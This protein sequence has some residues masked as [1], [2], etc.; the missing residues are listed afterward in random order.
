MEIQQAQVSHRRTYQLVSSPITTPMERFRARMSGTRR[1]VSPT[2]SACSTACDVDVSQPPHDSKGESKYSSAGSGKQEKEAATDLA[3]ETGVE[4]TTIGAAAAVDGKEQANGE[5]EGYS[6]ARRRFLLLVFCLASV[7]CLLHKG[8]ILTIAVSGYLLSIGSGLVYPAN[9]KRPGHRLRVVD[10]DDHVVFGCFCVF[11]PVLGQSSRVRP[12][13]RFLT[14]LIIQHVFPPSGFYWRLHPSR[15]HLRHR[16]RVPR[17]DQLL[18]LP[19]S[20]RFVLLVH[21]SCRI[22]SDH[23]YLPRGSGACVRYHSLFPY[24]SRCQRRRIGACRFLWVHRPA[25]SNAGVEVVL[26][27]GSFRNFQHRS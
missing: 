7:S 19:R 3:N 1:E 12:S 24:R 8:K 11:S 22:P 25:G 13:Q 23:D 4:A 17:N 10:M 15:I 6:K 27:V 18:Y 9:I 26:S 5:I 20:M 2:T 14:A 16:L 21:D